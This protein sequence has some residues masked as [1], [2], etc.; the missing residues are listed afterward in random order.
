MPTEWVYTML[1][2]WNFFDSTP[3]LPALEG[4]KDQHKH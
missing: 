3:T 1:K 4:V 2:P